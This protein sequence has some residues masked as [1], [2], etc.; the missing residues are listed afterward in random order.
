MPEY[1][2]GIIVSE[3][4]ELY[5]NGFDVNNFQ[6]ASQRSRTQIRIRF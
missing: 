6:E 5:D 1:T 3:N 2:S 4:T